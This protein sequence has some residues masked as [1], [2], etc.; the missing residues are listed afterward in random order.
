[1]L[2]GGRDLRAIL[3]N[4]YELVII[5]IWGSFYYL[6]NNIRER[7]MRPGGACIKGER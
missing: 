7:L 1:M 6:G 2:Q 4:R 5:F 3:R